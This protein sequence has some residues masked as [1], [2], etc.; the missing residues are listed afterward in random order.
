LKEN[1]TT[2]FYGENLD[3]IGAIV[4]EDGIAIAC[5]REEGEGRERAQKLPLTRVIFFQCTF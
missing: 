2:K 4:G 5:E 3:A 1:K